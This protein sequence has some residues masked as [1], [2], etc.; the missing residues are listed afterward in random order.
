MTMNRRSAGGPARKASEPRSWA[1]PPGLA[2]LALALIGLVQAGCQSTGC[3]GCG[4]G[5]L[6]SRIGNGVQALGTRVANTGARIFNHKGGGCSTCGDGGGYEEGMIIDQGIPMAPGGMIVP[7]PAVVPVPAPSLESAPTQLEPIESNATGARPANPTGGT[8]SAGRNT[9]GVKGSAYEASAPRGK[10]ARGRPNDVAR[11]VL[12]APEPARQASESSYDSDDLLDNIPPVD[13]PIEVT[14]KAVSLPEAAPAHEAA[15]VPAEAPS[16]VPTPS[17]PTIAPVTPPAAPVTP[18]VAPAAETVQPA[19]PTPAE[20]ASAEEGPESIVSIR[21]APG[22][23]RSSS[24]APSVAGGSV[25]SSDGLAWLKEKGYKTLVDLRSI[26]EVDPNFVESVN[27]HGMAYLSLPIVADRLD[28]TR[29]ARFDDLISRSENH[30]VYFCDTDGTRAGLVW[31]LHLRTVDGVDPLSATQR[32]E[33]VGLTP[34]QAGIAEAYLA[35]QKS[36]SNTD[37]IPATGTT[38]KV[39]ENAVVDSVAPSALPSTPAGPAPAPAPASPPV[40][41]DRPTPPM[42]PGEH[43]PQASNKPDLDRFREPMAWRPVA[44]LVLAGVG[45]PLA[46]WSKTALSGLHLNR[47]KLASLPGSARRSLSGPAGS[48]A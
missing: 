47:R 13:V 36:R 45:V 40:S 12:S 28:S 11:A 20:T 26:S 4:L 32:S 38:P 33:D 23:L 2:M 15:P 31:Y 5:G 24:V 3:N 6:G 25:P 29:L 22:I 30:P 16:L 37:P 46:Y 34:T 27:D 14:R 17:S 44:A 1:R 19:T 42:L 39:V 18:P 9:P 7:A 48:D 41:A 8:G 35:G 43:R 10:V 21:Q